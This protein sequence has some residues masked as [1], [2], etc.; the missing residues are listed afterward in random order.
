MVRRS[1]ATSAGGTKS[2]VEPC[3]TISGIPPTA[4]PTTGVPHAIASNTVLG[5]LSCS[6]GITVHIGGAIDER[7]PTIVDR[8]EMKVSYA[9]I[10]CGLAMTDRE[11]IQLLWDFQTLICQQR[12]SLPAVGGGIG[13]EQQ[14]TGVRGHR[15]HLAGESLI[16]G[17]KLCQVE[18]VW[19]DRDGKPVEKR[20]LF[21]LFC[22]PLTQG[23]DV[24]ARRPAAPKSLMFSSP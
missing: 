21:H 16:A 20:T 11:H 8:A 4:K 6:E 13:D 7:Q 5:R 1:A 17:C 10:Q 3:R 19:D 14:H 24:Q 15:E 12:E 2:P 18:S 9:A 23:N 22:H